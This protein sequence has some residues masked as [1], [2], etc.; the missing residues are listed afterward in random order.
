MSTLLACPYCGVQMGMSCM[1]A[2]IAL[3]NDRDSSRENSEGRAESNEPLACTR[4]SSS[5]SSSAVAGFPCVETSIPP[6]VPGDA[7]APKVFRLDLRSNPI[8]KPIVRD[9]KV[10]DLWSFPESERRSCSRRGLTSPPSPPL[11]SSNDELPI[12]EKAVETGLL[13]L[14]TGTSNTEQENFGHAGHGE[15]SSGKEGDGH[16][17]SLD[18]TQLLEKISLLEAANRELYEALAVQREAHE[19]SR[20]ALERTLNSL[21]DDLS[22]LHALV[23]GAIKS[24][25]AAHHGVVGVE[26]RLENLPTREAFYRLEEKVEDLFACSRT[27]RQDTPPRQGRVS[28]DKNEKTPLLNL[29]VNSISSATRQAT[30]GMSGSKDTGSERRG[31]PTGTPFLCDDAGEMIAQLLHLQPAVLIHT[32]GTTSALKAS[33]GFPGR[34]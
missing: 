28:R 5:L 23:A 25:D 6:R 27:L 14:P 10:R 26:T 7:N 33:D 15:L 2:H 24:A 19:N 3:C 11:Q 9:A 4:N 34:G 17:A 16:L 20:A 12:G 8:K 31:A 22:T 30:S 29:S 13:S 18:N 32:H 1:R 21:R